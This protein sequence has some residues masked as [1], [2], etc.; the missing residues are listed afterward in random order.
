MLDGREIHLYVTILSQCDLHMWYFIS[1][2]Q[3]FEIVKFA[4]LIG[5]MKPHVDQ[6]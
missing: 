4:K 6:V 3:N 2:F 5:V 1:C